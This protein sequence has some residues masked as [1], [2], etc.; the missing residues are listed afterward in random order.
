MEGNG[1][2]VVLFYWCLVLCD[3]EEFMTSAL[4]EGRIGLMEPM[5]P[6]FFF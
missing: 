2:L 6:F 5:A 3:V 4:S 1:I